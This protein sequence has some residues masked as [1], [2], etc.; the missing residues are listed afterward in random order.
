MPSGIERCFAT[1]SMTR[2]G[3]KENDKERGAEMLIKF[4]NSVAYNEEEKLIEVTFDF[5]QEKAS[6]YTEQW[7]ILARAGIN[8]GSFDQC[9]VMISLENK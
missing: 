8:G 4:V 5:K 3:C 1:L 2:G 7:F 9:Q 6:D